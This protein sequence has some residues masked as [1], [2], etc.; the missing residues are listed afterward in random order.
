M[1]Y[2]RPVNTQHNRPIGDSIASDHTPGETV[3]KLILEKSSGSG[4]SFSMAV[5]TIA[6]VRL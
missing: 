5:S 3:V 4:A 1:E 2:Q 6:L